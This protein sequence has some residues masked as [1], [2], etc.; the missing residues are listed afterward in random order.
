MRDSKVQSL[1][2]TNYSD[3]M[4]SSSATLAAHFPLWSSSGDTPTRGTTDEPPISAVV[5]A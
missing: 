1:D 4:A 3:R 5:G 2:E